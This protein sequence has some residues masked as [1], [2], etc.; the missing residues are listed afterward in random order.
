MREEEC[1]VDQFVDWTDLAGSAAQVVV[2]S[3]AGG[4]AQALRARLVRLFTRDAPEKAGES[5]EARRLDET[6]RRLDQ[7]EDR[8]TEERAQL[9]SWKRRLEVFLEDRPDAAEELA[10]IVDEYRRAHPDSADSSRSQIVNAGDSSIVIQ[11][12]RDNSGSV[13]R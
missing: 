9:I 4:A 3:V 10:R 8:T 2:E 7:A 5:P 13:N 12:G 6:D 1:S 11:A